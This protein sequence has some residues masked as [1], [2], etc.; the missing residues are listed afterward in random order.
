M[1]QLRQA[2]VDRLAADPQLSPHRQALVEASVLGRR[3]GAFRRVYGSFRDTGTAHLLAVSGLHLALVAS[4]GLALRRL[5]GAS[6]RMDALVLAFTALPLLLLVD[7]RPPLA[8]AAAMA[9]LLAFGP[10]IAQTSG[11]WHCARHGSAGG[12]DP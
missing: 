5:V 10:A 11:W 6:P 12:V 7:V 3:N 9:L 2:A 4:M 8:R 1:D